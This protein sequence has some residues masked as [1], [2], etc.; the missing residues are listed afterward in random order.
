MIVWMTCLATW[1]F[2]TAGIWFWVWWTTRGLGTGW[3]FDHGVA[4]L[5]WAALWPVWLVLIVTSTVRDWFW[6]RFR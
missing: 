2:V 4:L 5:F 1:A 3:S 6:Q